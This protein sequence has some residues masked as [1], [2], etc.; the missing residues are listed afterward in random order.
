MTRNRLRPPFIRQN[1]L[2]TRS[3]HRT[4]QHTGCHIHRGLCNYVGAFRWFRML[5][6][7]LTRRIQ[8]VLS[9][10]SPASPSGEDAETTLPRDPGGWGH[11][12]K[13]ASAAACSYACARARG[14][15]EFLYNYHTT[16]LTLKTPS[17]LE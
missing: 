7:R 15:V 1:Y 16:L 4:L 5:W 11:S 6:L 13:N 8:A 14:T 9:V 10:V 12:N 2:A 3:T 17:K